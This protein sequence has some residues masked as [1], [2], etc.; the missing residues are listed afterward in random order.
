MKKHT[1]KFLSLLCMTVILYTSCKK[2]ALQSQENNFEQKET[3]A[4]AGIPIVLGAKQTNAYTV[5]NML[6]AYK[7]MKAKENLSRNSSTSTSSLVLPDLATMQQILVANTKYVRVL[8]KNDEDFDSLREVYDTLEF[9][10]FPLDYDLSQIGNYYH[11]PT[12]PDSQITWQYVVLKKSDNISSYFQ[13]QTLTDNIFLAENSPYY[14]QFPETFWDQL[15]A[16]ALQQ[17]GQGNK[18]ANPTSPSS[19]RYRPNGN[20]KVLDDQLEQI[21]GLEGAKIMAYASWRHSKA[22]TDINGNFSGNHTFITKCSYFIK[23]ESDN[24]RGRKYDIRSGWYGQ[25]WTFLQGNSYN[26]CYKT[27]DRSFQ[28]G[29]PLFYASI[30]RGIYDVYFHDPFGLSNPRIRLKIWGKDGGFLVNPTGTGI[31]HPIASIVGGPDIK[32]WRYEK[33]QNNPTVFEK[34][35]LRIYGTTVHEVGH[36]IQRSLGIAQ[37]S[38]CSNL[39]R[40]SWADCVEWCFVMHKYNAPNS[41]Y[42]SNTNFNVINDIMVGAG[43]TIGRYPFVNLLNYD[44]NNPDNSKI[45]RAYS[46]LFIDIIDNSPINSSWRKWGKDANGNSIIVSS[47]FLG[48]KVSNYTLKEIENCLANKDWSVSW[49]ANLDHVKTWLYNNSTNPTKYSLETYLNF[50]FTNYE[51]N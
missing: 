12:L 26:A 3:K 48:E 2:D 7:N 17:I 29:L 47:G 42:S 49:R 50:Y 44:W 28:T 14:N 10:D 41:I 15:E 37:F 19:A 39:I 25:A 11:D 9:S 5:E 34:N 32:I 21:I 40:E 45:S 13:Q 46:P 1:I 43:K 4:S 30:H 27:L 33:F 36:C 24:H 8:P 22:Y 38:F 51:G 6:E 23:W 18:L 16:T 20:I 35:T 31:T